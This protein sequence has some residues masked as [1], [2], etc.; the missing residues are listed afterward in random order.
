MTKNIVIAK[1]TSVHGIKGSVKLT[2]FASNP[3][4]FAKYSG[5]MFDA[6]NRVYK[7]KIIS[8]IPSQNNDGFIVKIDGVEDRNQA[9]ALRN[10]ELFV[11]RDQLKKNKKDEFYY[12]DLV[13]LDVLNL[14]KKKIGKVLEVNDFGAGGV[15]EIEF[16]N[17]TAHQ[18]F[19]FTHQIFPE[20]NIEKGFLILDIPEEIA[21]EGDE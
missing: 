17:K 11:N 19:S 14:D 6:Q 7:V 10:T 9:E 3:A 16:E 21:V 18:N 13:G 20:V 2:S 1:I 5:K 8:Q 15:V 4:D 12:V